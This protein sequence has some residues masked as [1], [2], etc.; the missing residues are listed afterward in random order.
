MPRRGENIRKRKDQRWEG[1]YIQGYDAQGKAQYKSVY[2]KT[3]VEVKKKLLAA[4]NQSKPQLSAKHSNTY[5]REVLFLWLQSKK[6]KLKPQTYGKYIYLMEKHIIPILGQQKL[7]TIQPSIIQDFMSQKKE[8]G[9]LDNKGGLSNGTLKTILYLIRAALDYARDQDPGIALPELKL[10]SLP[11]VKK[12]TIVLQREEQAKLER[13]IRNHLDP[14][15]LGILLC[16][17]TGIRLGEICGLRWSDIDLTHQLIHIQRTLQRIKQYQDTRSSKGTVMMMGNPKTPSSKRSIPIP[18]CLTP[19]LQK[20]REEAEKDGYVI[21]GRYD[22]YLEP[23]TYQYRFKSYLQAAGV[24]EINFHALRHTFATRC[25]EA[26]FEAKSLSEI[27]GHA[28]VNIT[29]NRYVHSLA[30]QKRLQ[31]ELLTRNWGQ[32]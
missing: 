13:Y 17:Y 9:R 14:S 5:F 26:G 27:L 19:M 25:M 29:L 31:M 7:K 8:K 2:A 22:V 10:P 4:T 15:T 20:Q 23:R 6:I 30:E 28:S 32:P 12:E 3:Y 18:S 21:T 1:R 24:R 11:G 16:L